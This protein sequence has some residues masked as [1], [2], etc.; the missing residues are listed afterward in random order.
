VRIARRRFTGRTVGAVAAAVGLVLLV[1]GFI[2]YNTN[3]LNAY[4]SSAES[5]QRQAEYERRYGRYDGV[6][7]PQLTATE[8]H[9]EIYPDR[10]EADVRGVHHLVNRTARPIDTIHVAVSS[11]VET[12]EIEFGRPARAALVDDDLGHR[13][14]VLDEPLQPGDS[15]RL[16]WQ[17][18]YDPRGFPARGISTAVVENGSFIV[19]PTWTPLIGYQP[20]RELASAGER[21]EHGRRRVR[22]PITTTSRPG[23]PDR[24]GARPRSPSALRRQTPSLPVSCAGRG[25]ATAD[26]GSSTRRPPPSGRDTPSFPPIMPCA[27]RARAMSRSK[28]STIPGTTRTSRA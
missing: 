25:R 7:Q 17:V 20:R 22:R 24:V 26:P 2:F 12:G 13:I 4:H 3:V 28:C 6:P 1:G 23:A 18:G 27:D 9:V 21:R 19:M 11:L 16:S 15:L 10:R 5:A 14:Y 8:L